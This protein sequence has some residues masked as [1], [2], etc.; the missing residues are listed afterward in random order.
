[1]MKPEIKQQWVDAL[2]SGKYTQGRGR[3]RNQAGDFCCLGVLCDLAAEAGVGKWELT[4]ACAPSFEGGPD[5]DD[6]SEVKLPGFV[7]QWA[8]LNT[9]NPFVHINRGTE[10][11]ASLNDSG[12]SFNRIADLIEAEL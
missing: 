6:V 12:K 4:D 1:M 8:G 11:L 10:S 2:R 9:L 3:L 7:K 5:L